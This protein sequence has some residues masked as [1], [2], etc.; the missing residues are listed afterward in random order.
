MAITGW[1]E[2]ER[3]RD[4]TQRRGLLR[5]RLLSPK[6]EPSGYAE[7]KKLLQRGST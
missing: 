2:A 5:R 3:S 6:S 1:T 4:N 7:A